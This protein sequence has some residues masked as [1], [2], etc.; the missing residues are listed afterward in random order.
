MTRC[1]GGSVRLMLLLQILQISRLS[2]GKNTSYITR[3]I[4]QVQHEVYILHSLNVLLPG[5]RSSGMDDPVIRPA[6]KKYR[7]QRFR[8]YTVF[9]RRIWFG[10]GFLRSVSY[11]YKIAKT[12]THTNKFTT[13][14]EKK[15]DQNDVFF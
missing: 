13:M 12:H 2:R 9:L 6:R 1:G 15:I 8:R 7:A 4:T 3:R 5:H 11:T 14:W 10:V